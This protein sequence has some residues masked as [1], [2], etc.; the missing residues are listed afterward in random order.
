MGIEAF[1][2]TMRFVERDACIHIREALSESSKI[3]FVGTDLDKT[4]ELAEYTDGNHIIE[5][6]ISSGVECVLAIRFSLCSFPTIDAV[7]LQL[8]QKLLSI[9]DAEVW[10]M[11]SALN[12]KDHYSPGDSSWLLAILPEEIEAMR[13]YWQGVFGTK[14]GVVRVKDT[15]NFAQK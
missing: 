8:V 10:L 4:T 13:K 3:R 6:Q 15:F 2:L 7:F 11:T 14:Q 12:Q 5:F 1:G 9:A